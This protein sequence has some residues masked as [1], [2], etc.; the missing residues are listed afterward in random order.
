LP[1]LYAFF[2][3]VAKN[4]SHCSIRHLSPGGRVKVPELAVDH[5]HPTNYKVTNEWSYTS[6][7]PAYFLGMKRTFSFHTTLKAKLC[8]GRVV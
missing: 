2:V 4:A 3:V 1:S 6:A 8:L 7:L 5:S